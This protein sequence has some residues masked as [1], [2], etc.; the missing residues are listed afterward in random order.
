MAP[1]CAGAMGVPGYIRP[2]TPFQ[3]CRRFRRAVLVVECCTA[4]PKEGGTPFKS[5]VYVPSSLKIVQ[6][7]GDEVAQHGT[8]DIVILESI[9]RH[10]NL[11]H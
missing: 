3:F 8:L 4:S 6:T 2:R 7:D 11:V 5:S 1:D 9:N 10:R